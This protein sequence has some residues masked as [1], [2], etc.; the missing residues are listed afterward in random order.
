MLKPLQTP[1]D[2]ICWG[3]FGEIWDYKQAQ[4][5]LSNISCPK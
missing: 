2:F 4:G 5:S 3:F 1:A